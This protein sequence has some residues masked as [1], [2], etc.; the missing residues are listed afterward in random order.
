M[1]PEIR[2][3]SRHDEEA[4]YHLA[5][6]KARYVGMIGSRRKIKLIFE[7][8]R[9]AGIAAQNLVRVS[10]IFRPTAS[11]WPA[12]KASSTCTPAK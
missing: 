10:S 6:S 2:V 9:D 7:S 12:R 4:L 3:R 1:R 5:P 11:C 8:L